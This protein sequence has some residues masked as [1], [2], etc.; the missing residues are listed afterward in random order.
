V[1]RR[2]EGEAQDADQA[3]CQGRQGNRRRRRG[4][5]ESRVGR[6]GVPREAASR[7]CCVR[8]RAVPGG[9]G[10]PGRVQIPA[11]AGAGRVE[12]NPQPAG[13]RV[14]I[15]RRAHRRRDCRPAPGGLASRRRRILPGSRGDRAQGRCRRWHLR[16]PCGQSRSGS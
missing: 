1:P 12:V 14:R 8:R 3:A 16:R 5:Q 7:V 11:R 15:R 4:D 6:A 13:G 2:A 10:C 9:R